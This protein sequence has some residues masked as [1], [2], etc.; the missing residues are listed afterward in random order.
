MEWRKSTYSANG[1]TACVET[2]S[3]DGMIFVR[4]TT[5]RHGFE[6]ALSA[7][8]WQAFTSKVKSVLPE[9]QPGSGH[10]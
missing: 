6:L 1:G 2:A 7:G 5:N 9:T 3:D 4:D 10:L 8:A